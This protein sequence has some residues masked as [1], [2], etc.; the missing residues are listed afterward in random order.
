MLSVT[1]PDAQ[2]DILLGED[3][4]FVHAKTGAFILDMST[5]DV[6]LSKNFAKL[7]AS[8][9]LT[10][11]DSPVF[12]SKDESWNGKLDIVWGGD[13]SVGRKL[14]TIFAAI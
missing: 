14:N 6:A 7:A 8:N 9:N 12:G 5:T 13:K 4:V 1:G 3:G 10:Y 2:K 11:I